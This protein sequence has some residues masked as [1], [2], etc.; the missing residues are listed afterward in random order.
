M[1]A[2]ED[3]PRAAAEPRR[4]P[5]RGALAVATSALGELLITLGVVMGLFV[6]YSLWWTNVLANQ[7]A[8]QAADQVRDQWAEA[9]PSEPGV[10]FDAEGGL[11]FLHIPRFGDDYEVLIEKGTT[12]EVLD[13]GVAGYY[14]EPYAAA[15]PWE[16]EGNF[17][18]AAHRDG[19]GAKFHNLHQLRE[20]DQIVVETRDTWYVYTVDATLPETT[21]Y[22]TGVIAP[23]PEKAGYEEPGRYIT[24]TTCTPMYTS[25][26]RMVVWGSLTEEI[27][28]DDQRTPPPALQAAAPDQG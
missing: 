14:T 5:R 27:P 4:A 19:H 21:R 24:L 7:E 16:E 22:D 11:G 13:G 18:L 10:P 15:M 8:D 25:R 17:S 9:P 6:V 1:E 20:G 28:V 23:V 26:Y 3:S 2:P 12:D